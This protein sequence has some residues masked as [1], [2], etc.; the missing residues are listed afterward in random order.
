MSSSSEGWTQ[1]VLYTFLG[2]ETDGAYPLSGVIRGTAGDLYGTA[3][4]GG[5]NSNDGVVFEILN[6]SGNWSEDILY[7]FTDGRDGAAPYSPLVFDASGNLYG[8]AI[9]GGVYG[10]GTIYKLI[11]GS[12]GWAE[13]TL[14]AFTGGDNGYTPTSGVSLDAA[15]NAY[16]VTAY[17]GLDAVGN[18]YKL[19]PTHNGYWNFSTVHNFT[20][21][22]DGGDPQSRPVIDQSGN[23]Y[24]TT[25]F[26][27]AY[28]Y[29]TVYKLALT[30][31][32]WKETVLHNFTGGDD[33]AYPYAGLSIDSAGTLYGTAIQGGTNNLGVVFEITQ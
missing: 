24:G 18:V 30:N 21:G 26:G 22:A 9:N 27:G 4:G 7:E 20:G 2:G 12:D 5:V 15:G 6:S 32:A 19:T 3:D 17:G 13:E 11:P 10:N 16:G 33:G 25:A 28:Q 29:G 8:T 31:G 23:L 14:Y 1:S